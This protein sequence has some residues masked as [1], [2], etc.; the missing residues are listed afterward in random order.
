[1][2]K[3]VGDYRFTLLQS[4]IDDGG[5]V[6]TPHDWGWIIKVRK[7]GKT[8]AHGSYY[9]MTGVAAEDL[10]SSTCFDVRPGG[11]ARGVT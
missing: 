3:D 4:D 6:N 1:M 7:T 2:T 10:V 8:V 5:D 9:G 11:V